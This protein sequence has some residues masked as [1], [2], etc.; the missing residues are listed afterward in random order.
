MI[1]STQGGAEP[2]SSEFQLYTILCFARAKGVL[3]HPLDT[4]LQPNN[5]LYMHNNIIILS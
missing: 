1:D 3:K 4:P 5:K 2:V